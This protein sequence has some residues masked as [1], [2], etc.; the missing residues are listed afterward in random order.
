MIYY[1]QNRPI[2]LPPDSTEVTVKSFDPNWDAE[3]KFNGDRCKLWYSQKPGLHNFKNFIF[4]NRH[5]E[6]FR[7]YTPSEE[8]LD[9]LC[10]LNL[11]M[12]TDLDGEL[13][14]FKTKNIKHTIIFYDVYYFG[15]KQIMEELKFR[16]EILHDCF[17]GK[18]FKC[19][20]IA[21]QYETD[22]QSV[23][24]DVIKSEEVEG[25]VMKDKRG[26]IQWNTVKSPDVAWLFKIRRPAKNYQF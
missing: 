7:K 17:K 1:F 3:K 23:F 6:V 9:E 10:S 8:I 26:K 5:K 2:L 22:F 14:H 12:E 25:L 21:E 4:W 16:R 20:K 18:N 13:L 15:N 24:S 19:L 11:P